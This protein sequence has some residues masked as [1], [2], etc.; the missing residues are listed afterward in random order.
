MIK[1]ETH[2]QDLGF[3]AQG[4]GH[5][6]R[7]NVILGAFGGICYILE[8]FLFLQK[9]TPIDK[10]GKMKM[11]VTSLGSVSIHLDNVYTEKYEYIMYILIL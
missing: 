7:S 11:A 2:L 5:Y 6:Q 3:L 1:K 9:F 10:G 4:E 8:Q